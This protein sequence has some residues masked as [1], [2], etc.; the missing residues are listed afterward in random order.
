METGKKM[1]G[2]DFLH[3]ILNEGI[4]SL[5]NAISHAEKGKPTLKHYV[6]VVGPNGITEIRNPNQ[7]ATEEDPTCKHC[8][9][10]GYLRCVDCKGDGYVINRKGL[11][12]KNDIEECEICDGK[13]DVLCPVCKGKGVIVPEPEVTKVNKEQFH[14]A[15]N[16][17]FENQTHETII[18]SV[19]LKIAEIIYQ[20]NGTI[21]VI[22]E[23]KNNTL[24]DD[25]AFNNSL[26]E[27]EDHFDISIDIPGEF[28][29]IEEQ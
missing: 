20:E 5:V 24:L 26:D 22:P 4:E 14:N 23:I 8:K 28:Y 21:L 16:A 12:Q 15:L 6:F 7:N 29:H 9:G 11:G 10:D 1:N 17:L 19:K 3:H 2:S 27:I 13:G 25:Q 18:G